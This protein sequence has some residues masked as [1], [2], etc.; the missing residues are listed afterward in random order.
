MKCVLS[1]LV[2]LWLACL[3][4]AFILFFVIAPSS[5]CPAPAHKFKL[6]L[7][8]FYCEKQV[9]VVSKSCSEWLCCFTILYIVYFSIFPLCQSNSFV[10]ISFSLNFVLI[11]HVYIF[12]LA[13]KVPPYNNHIQR[14]YNIISLLL[15][16][17]LS[18]NSKTYLL[19]IFIPEFSYF[20]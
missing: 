8:L 20:F 2:G 15:V 7:L 1:L 14:G 11:K 9:C 19:T 10:I 12:C 17:E 5:Q 18:S 6:K 13:F 4:V 16:F 3:F